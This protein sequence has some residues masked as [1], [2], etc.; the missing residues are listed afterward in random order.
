[1]QEGGQAA[2]FFWRSLPRNQAAAAACVL[3]TLTAPATIGFACHQ[4]ISLALFFAKDQ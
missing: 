1:V 2:G 3:K 4:V